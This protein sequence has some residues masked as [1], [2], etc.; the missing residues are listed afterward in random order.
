MAAA[1]QP[2]AQPIGKS[3]F[4][5]IPQQVAPNPYFPN[6][7]FQRRWTPVPSCDPPQ[8]PPIDLEKA[9][10]WLQQAKADLLAAHYNLNKSEEDDSCKFPALVCF[11]THDVVEKCLKG[12]L[13]AKCGLPV[14]L[15]DSPVVVNLGTAI[16]KPPGAVPEQFIAVV[17]ECT[18]Q[19]NEHVAKSR[20]PNYQVPPCAPAT[21]YT[22]LQA[23]EA[24][25][26]AKKLMQNAA[27]LPG[28]SE[29]MGDLNSLPLIRPTTALSYLEAD[30]GKK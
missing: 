24:L 5:Q 4:S 19:V 2:P 20:Y 8:P 14:N 6:Y 28:I 18:M 12:V 22:V 15:I 3:R 26:A 11:L 27:K 21:V 25:A 17:K 7:N 30:Q 1:Y 29:L 23:T 13:Y 16:E 10:M 9:E